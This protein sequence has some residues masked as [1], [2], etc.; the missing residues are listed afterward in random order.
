MDECLNNAKRKGW[1]EVKQGVR[2]LRRQI[3]CLSSRVPSSFTFRQLSPTLIRIYFLC[4][5][6]NGRETTIFY[7]DVD[8]SLGW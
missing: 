6:G 3:T 7:S 5:P 1:A 8:T 2:E 4:S